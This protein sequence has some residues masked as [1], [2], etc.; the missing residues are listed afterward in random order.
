MSGKMPL[1]WFIMATSKYLQ[2]PCKS[3]V[4]INDMNAVDFE[5]LLY[6]GGFMPDKLRREPKV[7]Q[8]IGDLNDCA[9]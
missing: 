8:L 9:N 7:L 1:W 5:G 3:D 2:C 6:P 4:T